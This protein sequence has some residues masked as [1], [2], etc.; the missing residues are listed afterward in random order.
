MKPLLLI[1]CLAT[2]A[3]P[4]KPEWKLLKEMSGEIPDHPGL[5]VETRASQIARGDDTVKLQIRWDFPWGAP[6]DLLKDHVLWGFDPSSI[7]RV[8]T[9]IQFNCKTLTVKS[10][11]YS[12]VYQ[13]NG[14]KLKSRDYPFSIDYNH[15]FAEYFCERGETPK[16]APALKPK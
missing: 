6:R 12:D 1:L 5:T 7:S 13:F 4:Q 10:E 2:Y 16:K 3:A 15:I 9:K 14:K 11:K 8:E